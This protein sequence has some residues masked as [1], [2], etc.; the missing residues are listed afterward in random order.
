MN[1]LVSIPEWV[2][3]RV[4]PHR[5]QACWALVAALFRFGTERVIGDELRVYLALP[6]GKDGA[7]GSMTLMGRT[8]LSRSTLFRAM[9]ELEALGLL[10]RHAAN[11]VDAADGLSFPVLEP[12]AWGV[13]MTPTLESDGCQNDTPTRAR[14]D[15]MDPIH[16]GGDPETTMIDSIDRE[17][18]TTKRARALADELEALGFTDGA[19]VVARHGEDVVAAALNRLE[20]SL[21]V[22][23]WRNGITAERLSRAGIRNAPGLVTAWL[24]DPATAW[25]RDTATAAFARTEDEV[26]TEA[27]A[28]EA[29]KKRFLNGPLGW[30][31]RS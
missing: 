15:P 28:F 17:N 19:G 16:G 26:R 18:T 23:G 7:H 22:E 30:V 27:D 21:G 8:W 4:L 29:A 12:A 11:R 1:G 20:A 9:D 14:I 5:R 2:I 10:L 6:K 3:D 13:K 24:R 31:V 25:F